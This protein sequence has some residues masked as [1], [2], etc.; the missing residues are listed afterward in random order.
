M[1]VIKG[2]YEWDS[3][4]DQINK[5]KHGLSF[6]EAVYVFDDPDSI[7][8]YDKEHSNVDEDRFVCIGNIGGCLICNVVYTDRWGR[9]RL[10][11][12]RKAV[13]KEEATYNEHFAKTH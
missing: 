2:L 13:P 9:I 4:K 3:E 7:E 11:S 8:F 1:T 12:A 10:I 6:D 5:R